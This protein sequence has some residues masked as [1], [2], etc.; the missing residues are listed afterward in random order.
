M[1]TRRK[2]RFSLGKNAL[3]IKNKTNMKKPFKM[4][5]HTLPGIN[6]RSEG[7]TDL[8]D[9]R[10]GS[11]PFQDHDGTPNSNTKTHFAD[12]SPKS[13]REV[14]FSKRHDAEKAKEKTYTQ[15]K[16]PKYYNEDGSVKQGDTDE[17]ELSEVKKDKDGRRYVEKSS[18]IGG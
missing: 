7:N 10:S 12:G 2:Q 17:G 1:G 13:K 11:S 18:D 6:Q 5:G 8:P 16:H 9:G 15:Y 3:G 4:K 14:D